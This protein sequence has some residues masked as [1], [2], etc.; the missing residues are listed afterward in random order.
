[1]GVNGDVD[2]NPYL[3]NLVFDA[4]GSL[5][6]TWNWRT[7]SDSKSR[8]KG[9]SND[10]LLYAVSP[11]G[12]MLAKVWFRQDGTRYASEI[13]QAESNSDPSGCP[14]SSSSYP[15]VRESDQQFLHGSRS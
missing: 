15:K 2:V 8:T 1:M 11:A 13:M 4:A 12:P 5:H 3:N 6:M 10:N 9:L 7:G 14:K